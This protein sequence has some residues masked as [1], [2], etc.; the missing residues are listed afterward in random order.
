[1]LPDP[2]PDDPR[3]WEGWS[4]YN[5]NDPYERLCL[6]FS[7][8]PTNEQIEDHTRRLQIWWQKKLPLKNQPSNPL[9]QLLRAGIDAAPRHIAEARADLLKPERRAEIDAALTERQRRN[10]LAE[11]QKFLDFA[12][13][14]KVLTGEEEANLFKLGRALNLS[15]Q[16]MDAAIAIGL[17]GTGAMREADL[18]P[19]APPPPPPPPPQPAPIIGAAEPP[20]TRRVRTAQNPAEDFRRMLRLSGL[21]EDSMSDERRD[22]FIDMAENLG[23]NGGDAEDMVDEYLEA[24]ADGTASVNLPPSAGPA[25]TTPRAPAPPAGMPRAKVSPGRVQMAPPPGAPRTTVLAPPAEILSREQEMQRYD[26]AFT[27]GIGAQMLFIPSASFTMGSAAADAPVNEQPPTRVTLSRFYLSRHPVTNAQYEQFAPEH[28]ARRGAW[29]GADH[30]A[31]YVS[32]LDAIKFCQWLSARERKRFRLPT[33]AE[34][35]YAARGGDNRTYPWGETAGQGNLANF[36]D[37]NTTFAWRDP[38][39]NDGYAETSPVGAYPAGASPFGI[40]DLSGNV[41]EWCLDYYETYKG[42]ERANPRGPQHGAQRVYRGGSWK[43][44]FASLKA[45]ARGYNQPTYASNDVGFRIVS[46]CE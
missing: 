40:E 6:S 20:R 7:S 31:I 42:G 8:R 25:V 36:A 11:F 39:V 23:L 14:D 17:E 44:R 45:T 24:I 30:P 27:C 4:L 33:E 38:A 15:P 29:A 5:S 35:E 3:K 16:D 32:S 22:T 46:E 28:K 18:P 26:P 19:A 34:W 21:D 37:A 41:W 9:A 12:L 10:G 1:M 43:S 13:S 2:L